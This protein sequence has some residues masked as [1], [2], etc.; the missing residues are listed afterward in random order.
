MDVE[1][2]AAGAAALL[3]APAATAAA[4]E[5]GKSLWASLMAVVRSK[6]AGDNAAAAMVERVMAEPTS[7][8]QAAVATLLQEWASGDESFAHELGRLVEAARSLPGM[9]QVMVNVSG[10]A[11]IGKQV[12]VGTNVG[13]IN[14]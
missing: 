9:G 11:T 13:D 5:A 2:I 4:G 10:N 8:R 1:A 6:F 7:A 3:A 14:L 12:N